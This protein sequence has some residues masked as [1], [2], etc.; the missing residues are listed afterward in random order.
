MIVL[1][2]ARLPEDAEQIASID[3]SF[4]T[5]VIYVPHRDGIPFYSINSLWTCQLQS[6]FQWM[7]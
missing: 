3:N 5:D 1:R 6:G 4:T 7:I 2:E